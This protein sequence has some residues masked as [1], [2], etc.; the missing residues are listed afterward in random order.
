[1]QREDAFT[2]FMKETQPPVAI[3]LTAAFG[4]DWAS[5]ATAEAFVYVW[6]NWDRI[7]EMVN[8]AGY[9]YRVARSRIRPFRARRPLQP[10]ASPSV[11]RHIEPGLR[12]AMER[13]SPRQRSV[14]VLVEGY[15]FTHHEVAG[16][17][18]ISRSSVRR[19]L[20]RGLSKLRRA[21]GVSV[22]E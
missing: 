9:V 8:P 2:A 18:G 16:N 15:G 20:E 13:L 22:H 17:L 3:A 19:H 6:Q 14:V 1:M 11:E 5:E 21:L 10:T 7:S 4:P 12:T